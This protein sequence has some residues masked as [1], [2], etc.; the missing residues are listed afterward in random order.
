MKKIIFTLLL[1][2]AAM[3]VSAQGQMDALR[4]YESDIMGTARYMG[5]G[6]AFNAL[7]GD[8]TA[9][10]KNPAGLGVYRRSELSFGTNMSI[11]KSQMETNSST[12]SGTRANFNFNNFALVASFVNQNASSG[13]IASNFAVTYDRLKN[14]AKR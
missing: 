11:N 3:C 2:A 5:M 4:F 8:A 6:G 12:I 1:V 10:S 9:I 7:G 13:L 14:F